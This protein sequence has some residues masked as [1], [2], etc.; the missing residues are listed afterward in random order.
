MKCIV[1]L[2]GPDLFDSINGF[3]PL[4]LHGGIPIL[5]QALNRRAWRRKLR[6]DDFVFVVRDVAEIRTLKNALGFHWPGCRVVELSQLT[7][8]ALLTVV[9]GLAMVGDDEPVIVDL[10]DIL[11]SEG[12]QDPAADLG[13]NVGAIVPVFRSTSSAYSYLRSEN[14]AVVEAA[15]KTRHQRCRVGRCLYVQ[16]CRDIAGSNR[17]F[18][19]SSRRAS[20]SRVAIR[21][22]RSEWCS[23]SWHVRAGP[24]V[25][26]SRTDRQ[27]TS[28]RRLDVTSALSDTPARRS[29]RSR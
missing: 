19:P 17:T 14:G 21:R 27:A 2:A 22:P 7:Q 20:V 29:S 11:F 24:M 18:D 23:G 1:P 4:V 3:R 9:A 8:G 25:E 15:E 28:Q 26:S 16:G 6:D 5:I 12:P 10:A 13:L